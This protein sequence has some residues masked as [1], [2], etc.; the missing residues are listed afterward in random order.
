MVCLSTA[1]LNFLPGAYMYI[2]NLGPNCLNKLKFPNVI[3]ETD[4]KS[5]F[6]LLFHCQAEVCYQEAVRLFPEEREQLEDY[7]KELTQIQ[8]Q[9]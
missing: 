8:Q 7:L 5:S 9:K 2:I 4:C 3:R 1:K 6:G